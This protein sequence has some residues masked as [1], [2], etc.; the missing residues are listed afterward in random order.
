[1][2]EVSAAS[3]P[4]S[5]KSF[6]DE[7]IN[8]MPPTIGSQ[9]TSTGSKVR[10]LVRQWTRGNAAPDD[11]MPKEITVVKK[12][13]DNQEFDYLLKQMREIPSF[14]PL[15]KSSV[16]NNTADDK[17]MPELNYKLSLQY[18]WR[19]QQHYQQCADAV[20]YGQSSLINRIKEV[21][22]ALSN[23]LNAAQVGAKNASKCAQEFST[24]NNVT[25][26]LEKIHTSINTI[27]A[28]MNY[29]NYLLPE[30][31]RLEEL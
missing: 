8:Y 20:C 1:M 11:I 23:Q 4:T 30:D 13:Q 27:K 14:Q 2:H 28:R 26:E 25:E 22:Q 31:I 12:S 21:D 9:S 15:L 10:Q 19:L 5:I 16:S 17:G 29:L 18:A 7:V 6:G 3:T 24:L